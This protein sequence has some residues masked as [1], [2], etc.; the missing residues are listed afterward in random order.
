MSS[1]VEKLMLQVGLN[2]TATPALKG[3]TQDVMK[4]SDLTNQSMMNLGTGTAGIVASGLAIQTALMPA[5]EMDR[6]LGEVKSLGVASDEIDLLAQTALEFS[7]DYGKSATDVVEAAYDIKSAFGDVNGAELSDITKSSAVLAAATK[8]D[9]QTITDY[10]GTMYGVFKNQADDLGVG[11]WSKNVAG[12]TAQSVEMFKTTGKGMSDAFTSVGA[13]ATAAGI[14]MNEQM[15]ILGTLQSTMSGSEAGTKYKAF[16]AG[17]GGAQDKLNMSFVDSQGAMLPMIDILHK[18]KGQF[19]DTLDV[20]ESDALKSAFGSAEAVS[21]IKLLMADT[22]GL[23][24]SINTLGDV[25][26]LTKAELMAGTMT[27]QFERLESS[28][29]ALRAAAGATILPVIADLTGG[30]ADGLM[31]LMGLTQEYPVLTEYLGYFG[32]AIM[33]TA[34]LVSMWKLSLGL[35]QLGM[36]G[37]TTVTTIYTGVVNGL[38]FAL[39]MVRLATLGFALAASIAQVP[40]LPLTLGIG[41][42][43]GAIGAVIYFWDDLK[44][45]WS[46]FSFIK[47]LGGMIDWI[48]EKLNYIPGIDI[49]APEFAGVDMPDVSQQVETQEVTKRVNQPIQDYMG[50]Y[51]TAVKPSAP[52]AQ[53]MA[54]YGAMNQ[55]KQVHTGDVYI[56][57]SASQISLADLD[58]TNELAV[59]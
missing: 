32:V 24:K 18:L 53:Q 16:L 25:T 7:A 36:V 19:G 21:M 54:N 42:V 2:D 9:T 57:T 48:V 52:L 56:H 1:S 45:A 8:A 12:M 49:D 26:G 17:V 11:I 6:K 5:I 55:G 34:G 22:D 44:A 10:M 50:S 20:A 35:A 58:E 33:A 15:A 23:A 3:I 39:K 14:E 59:G 27:D 47:M 29:F 38:S 28:W 37:L 30:M 46:D 43:V 51:Q 13:N 40:L 4:A 31:V 41:A